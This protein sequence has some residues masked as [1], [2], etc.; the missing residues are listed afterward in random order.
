MAATDGKLF[1]PTGTPDQSA[2]D[3]CSD[4]HTRAEIGQPSP[5]R[6]RSHRSLLYAVEEP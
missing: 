2:A 1:Y 5:K 4:A 3:F 6:V